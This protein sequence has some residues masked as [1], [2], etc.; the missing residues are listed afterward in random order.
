MASSSDSPGPHPRRRWPSVLLLLGSL[1]WIGLVAGTAVGAAW[2]VPEGSGLAGPA[3]ALGFGV[4]GV[5]IGLVLGAVLGWKAPHGLLRAAAAVGV[6]L[7][8]LAA[9]LVAWRIVADRA[10]R[11]AKA[12]MDV[13]LPPPAGFRIE[14]RVSELD[15]M[16]RYRELTVDADAWTATWVAAGPESATCTARLIPDEAHALLRKRAE[17]RQALD[18]F[19]SRCSPAGGS[20]THFYALRESAPGQPSWEVAADFQCLQENSD[21]SDL[22]RILGRIPIDAVSHGR[23]ECES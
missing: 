3:I 4:L 23:A 10:E 13:P 21:L 22:H 1:A 7:A 12:G 17:L 14:S 15:E 16:R 18:R 11:L 6:V 19:T 20:T 8:L 2:F 9:G 5:G